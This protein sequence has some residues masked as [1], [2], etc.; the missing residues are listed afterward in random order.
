M[1]LFKKRGV[2]TVMT[3]SNRS[4]TCVSIVFAATIG[5]LIAGL[6]AIF[7]PILDINSVTVVLL[8]GLAWLTVFLLVLEV[9]SMITRRMK[10]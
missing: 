5:I 10:K 2:G 9:V 4:C 3:I 7:L 6:Y 1:K 8:V